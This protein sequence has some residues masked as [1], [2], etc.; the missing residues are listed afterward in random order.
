MSTQPLPLIYAIDDEPD[1][2]FFLRHLVQKSGVPLRFQPFANGDAAVVA[3]STLLADPSRPALPLACFLDI[4]MVGMSGF[5]LLK[6]IRGQNGLDGV[7]VIMFSSSDD[8]RDIDNARA[9]GAQGFL[10]KY[11]SVTAMQTILDEA[12]DF[13]ALADSK[14]KFL[15][16]SYRFIGTED[17]V[18]ARL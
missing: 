2:I 16:W 7:P 18:A 10:K 13:A 14:K 12:R 17:G 1:D 11:P 9:L 6:W 8:P 3:L 4:K 15:N 5:E